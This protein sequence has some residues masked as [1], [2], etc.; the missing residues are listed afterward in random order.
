MFKK[1]ILLLLILF[2]STTAL[3]QQ[4]SYQTY[5]VESN[6]ETYSF[7]YTRGIKPFLDDFFLHPRLSQID[8]S[9]LKTFRGIFV[10]KDINIFAFGSFGVTVYATETQDSFIIISPHIPSYV[11]TFKQMIVYHEFYHLLT[12]ARHCTGTECPYVLQ[13]G[14]YIDIEKVIRTFSDDEKDEVMRHIVEIQN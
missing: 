6:G 11:P 8:L 5:T 13:S 2:I 12:R 14:Q 9:A 10:S 4:K 3:T 7:L 1:I